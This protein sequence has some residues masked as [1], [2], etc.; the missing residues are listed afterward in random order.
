MTGRTAAGCGIVMF[1]ACLM[2]GTRAPNAAVGP[3]VTSVAWIGKLSQGTQV[4]LGGSQFGGKAPAGPIKYDD[5]ETGQPNQIIGNGWGIDTSVN[6]N[7]PVYTN[8]Q[9]GP[10]IRMSVK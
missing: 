3:T 4:T 8:N 2:L 9:G 5:F 6:G 7:P 1:A 10:G